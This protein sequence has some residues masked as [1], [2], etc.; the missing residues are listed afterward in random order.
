M[1]ILLKLESNSEGGFNTSYHTHI[2]SMIY[3]DVLVEDILSIKNFFILFTLI[4]K[5]CYVFVKDI[6][7]TFLGTFS[8][9]NIAYL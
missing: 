6:C 3:D 9:E 7:E 8:I 1:E 5:L 4:Y 2:T